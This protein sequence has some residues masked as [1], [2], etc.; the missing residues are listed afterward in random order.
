M[1]SF[2]EEVRFVLT[3]LVLLVLFKML[4]IISLYL[5]MVHKALNIIL[6]QE[7]QIKW[8]YLPILAYFLF[9]LHEWQIIPMLRWYP[10]IL[11]VV[12]IR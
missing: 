12:G 4:Q 8:S 11:M 5:V 10:G 2:T 3:S 6:V 1:L 7:G 9:S